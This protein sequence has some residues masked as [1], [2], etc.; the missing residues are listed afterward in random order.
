MINRIAVF[1]PSF[2]CITMES[3]Q[4]NEC[5]AYYTSCL[6]NWLVLQYM[7]MSEYRSRKMQPAWGRLGQ[8]RTFRGKSV[9]VLGPRSS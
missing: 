7:P 2:P 8:R 1:V 3:C 9:V 6:P 5:H 4:A